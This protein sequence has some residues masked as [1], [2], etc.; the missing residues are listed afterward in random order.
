MRT[1]EDQKGNLY[2][3][4]DTPDDRRS[5]E[6][7]GAQA[8]KAI[9]RITIADIL[10]MREHPS[11]YAQL[12]RKCDDRSDNLSPEHRSRRNLHIMTELEV[13]SERERL[14]HG[15]VAPR[16]EHHHRNRAPRKGITNDEFRNDIQ[17]DLLTKRHDSS[18]RPFR[19]SKMGMAYLVIA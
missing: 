9:I 15:D 19:T 8:N 6:H 12:R 2:A 7:R 1:K 17:T 16:L 14:V 4:N 18:V 3:R 13:G 11:L 10:D 5:A